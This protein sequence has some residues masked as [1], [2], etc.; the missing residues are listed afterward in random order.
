MARAGPANNEAGPVPLEKGKRDESNGKQV[1]AGAAPLLRTGGIGAGVRG[2]CFLRLERDIQQV[3]EQELREGT[4]WRQSDSGGNH[5][6]GVCNLPNCIQRH[7]A[8]HGKHTV[9]G[10][11]AI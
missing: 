1:Q 2:A 6:P 7:Y 5:N 4:P 11:D 9:A 8:K 10:K 3:N